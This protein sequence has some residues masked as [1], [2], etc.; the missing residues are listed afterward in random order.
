MQDY[1]NTGTQYYFETEPY[2]GTLAAIGD[3]EENFVQ[4][5]DFYFILPQKVESLMIWAY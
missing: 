2:S 3:G 5:A 4:N 1:F